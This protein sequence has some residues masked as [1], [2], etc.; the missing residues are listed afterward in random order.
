MKHIENYRTTWHDTD[1]NRKVRPTPIL[2]YFEETSN[3]HMTSVGKPLDKV[4][5]E[6]G[7]GFILS[8]LTM[9]FY[10]PI[11]AYKDILVETWTSEGRAFSTV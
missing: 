4:R 10:K 7:I 2:T 3:L 8:R 11:E 9:K 6:A 5:D 1:C